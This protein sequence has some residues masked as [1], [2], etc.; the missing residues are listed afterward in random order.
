MGPGLINMGP[1][2]VPRVPGLVYRWVPD[3][4]H[5]VLP[6]REHWGWPGWIHWGTIWVGRVM[7]HTW[8]RLH[9]WTL[10]CHG[11]GHKFLG[12][13]IGYEG[14]CS[15]IECRGWV[16]TT[17]RVPIPCLCPLLMTVVVIR[18]DHVICTPFGPRFLLIDIG[19]SLLSAF[20]H[21]TYF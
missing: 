21:F 20:H 18:H 11:L 5:W 16:M 15:G 9:W 3:W 19:S 6:D 10:L 1:R 17:S 7:W 8:H 14:C 2:H 12:V 13:N 4:V